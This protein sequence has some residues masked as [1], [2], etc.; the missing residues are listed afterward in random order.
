MT[1]KIPT[2]QTMESM[3]SDQTITLETVNGLVVRK[4]RLN[5]TNIRNSMY[6]VE[7]TC[8]NVFK[9]FLWVLEEKR[10]GCGC[11]TPSILRQS[12]KRTATKKRRSTTSRVL[13]FDPGLKNFGVCFIANNQVKFGYYLTSPITE[14]KQATF[15]EVIQKFTSEITELLDATRPDILVVERFMARQFSAKIIELVATMIGI[16][17]HM[18]GVRGIRIDVIPSAQWKSSVKHIGDL[19]KLYYL[20]KTKYN[21]APHVI[22]AMCMGRYILSDNKFTP[23][24]KVWIRNNIGNCFPPRSKIQ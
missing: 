16:L 14:I 8:G 3:R 2:N 15:I 4:K 19:D 17:I 13:A 6:T 20:A 18:C 21:L 10:H 7:C 22:D 5:P 23:R 1:K 11:T 12:A 9:E 24:D